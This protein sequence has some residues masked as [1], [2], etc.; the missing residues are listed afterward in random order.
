M[1]A[2]FASPKVMYLSFFGPI[3]PSFDCF[4]SDAA[5]AS[6]KICWFGCHLG[7]VN[8][9]GAGFEFVSVIFAMLILLP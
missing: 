7:A 6:Q 9:F 8:G 4:V 1:S 3:F 5:C 2:D